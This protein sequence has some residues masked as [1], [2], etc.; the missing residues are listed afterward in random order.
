MR[1][2]SLRLEDFG[3]YPKESGLLGFF[4]HAPVQSARSSRSKIRTEVKVDK[5]YRNHPL[6]GTFHPQPNVFHPC[7]KR[8]V[9][10]SEWAIFKKKKGNFAFNPDA[11]DAF[12]ES[13]HRVQ[14]I[15]QLGHRYTL[16]ETLGRGSYA[17]VRKAIHNPSGKVVA[18]KT[19]SKAIL[20]NP[21]LRKQFDDMWWI[22]QRL[23]D[24]N[25]PFII[26]MLEL[27]ESDEAFYLV[28]EFANMGTLR[29]FLTIKRKFPEVCVK[30]IIFQ[31]A[32]AVKVLHEDCQFFHGDLSP[33]NILMAQSAEHILYPGDTGSTVRAFQQKIG[34]PVTGIFDKATLEASTKLQ[35]ECCIKDECG[36]IG[37]KT[38]KEILMRNKAFT[39]LKVFDVKLSD[40]DGARSIPNVTFFEKT[41]SVDKAPF[42]AMHGTSGY[43]APELLDRR[44]YTK[45]IDMWSMGVIIYE[46]LTGFKPFPMPDQCITTDAQFYPQEWT[47]FSPE[48][49]QVVR[50]LLTRNPEKRMTI[51]Q[52]LK[53]RWFDSVEMGKGC[54]KH[55]SSPKSP[56]KTP[57]TEPV[58]SSLS[59]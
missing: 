38:W 54:Y 33:E 21:A 56:P 4:S 30:S 34:V 42:T 11:T 50:A 48:C 40:F 13:T 22:H 25:S 35:K 36:F 55:A 39:R 23:T 45:A 46:A 15:S 37:H 24:T 2:S 8:F 51:K 9:G 28:Q 41:G 6:T 7:H 29:D 19:I 20:T 31:L 43:I 53:H 12:F 27:Y 1:P 17:N 10:F 57:K 58:P 44:P 32:S 26:R 52:L 18:I 59:L 3:Q 16:G 14:D 49:E 5:K 47:D